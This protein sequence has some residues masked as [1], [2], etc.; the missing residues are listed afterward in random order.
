[1]KASDRTCP[2]LARSMHGRFPPHY[3]LGPRVVVSPCAHRVTGRALR[4]AGLRS[5]AAGT[6]GWTDSRRRYRV[7]RE[8]RSRSRRSSDCAEV[9]Q[10]QLVVDGRR[11][12]STPPPLPSVSVP[13]RR[14]GPGERGP[15]PG[16]RVSSRRGSGRP[17]AE[18]NS[19]QEVI[20][21]LCNEIDS[22]RTG[23]SRVAS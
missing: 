8:D 23:A 10:C 14:P 9:T 6:D 13:P 18:L 15:G 1:M 3:L 12:S 16:G 17:A 5:T 22:R 2:F 7:A 20:G 19:G 4:F 11:R 21:T